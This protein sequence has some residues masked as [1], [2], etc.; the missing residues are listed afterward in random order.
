MVM[1]LEQYNTSVNGRIETKCGTLLQNE[2]LIS[3]I[4]DVMTPVLGVIR[5][6]NYSRVHSYRSV[7]LFFIEGL[8]NTG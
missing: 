7:E 5:C 6:S 1:T 2:R 4:F 8:V 3:K